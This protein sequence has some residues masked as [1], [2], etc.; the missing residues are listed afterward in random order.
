ME[1]ME[2]DDW[3]RDTE[4]EP[5]CGPNLEYDAAFMTLANAALGKPEQQYGETVIPAVDPDWKAV[6]AYGHLNWIP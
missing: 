3:L 1:G 5:P 4:V 6:A 2:V